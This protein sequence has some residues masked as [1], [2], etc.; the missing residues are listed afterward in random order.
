MYKYVSDWIFCKKK[1]L[2][3]YSMSVEQ[4]IDIECCTSIF[5]RSYT[6]LFILV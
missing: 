5:R 3:A 2:I 1:G 4:G 6:N